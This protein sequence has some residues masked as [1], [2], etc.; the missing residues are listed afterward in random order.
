MFDFVQE[1]FQ[2]L[3]VLGQWLEAHALLA[4][5]LVVLLAV[6]VIAFRASI[7]ISLVVLVIACLLLGGW[8]VYTYWFFGG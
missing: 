6:A 2:L 7:K 3:V 8:W 1:T 5:T 4:A